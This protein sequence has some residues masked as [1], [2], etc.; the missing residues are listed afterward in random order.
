M[1]SRQKEER[2]YRRLTLLPGI[3]G[4]ATF[5]D[6]LYSSN[7]WLVVVGLFISLVGFAFPR[8]KGKVEIAMGALKFKG[9]LTEQ[10]EDDEED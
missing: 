1:W 8:L 9:E 6:G 7:G 3:G 2:L 4:F 10:P 5:I